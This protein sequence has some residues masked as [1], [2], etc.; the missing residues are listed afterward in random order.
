MRTILLL[1]LPYCL[2][3]QSTTR[4]EGHTTK[5]GKY[6]HSYTKTTPNS[7]KMDNYSHKGNI[8]P[9]TGKKGHKK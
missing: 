1:L 3:G 8:N 7:T 2:F 6:V 9:Y 4:V 5:K